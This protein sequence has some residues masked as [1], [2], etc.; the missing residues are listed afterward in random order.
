MRDT[1]LVS[2]TA[3]YSTKVKFLPTMICSFPFVLL[4]AE[5]PQLEIIS[6][7]SHRRAGHIKSSQFMALSTNSLCASTMLG[8][9]HIHINVVPTVL[10]I[11]VSPG[12]QIF[13]SIPSS[14]FLAWIPG[15]SYHQRPKSSPLW[16]TFFCIAFLV[17]TLSETLCSIFLLCEQPAMVQKQ[18]TVKA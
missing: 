10:M 5:Q 6:Q 15:S 16:D 1:G 4:K 14:L 11:W 3:L 7:K 18:Q 9:Q 2:F 12:P 8:N 13:P 17:F